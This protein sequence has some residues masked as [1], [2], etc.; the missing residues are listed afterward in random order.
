VKSNFATDSYSTAGGLAAVA[1]NDPDFFREVKNQIFQQSPTSDLDPNLPSSL[2]S[3]AFDQ[4]DKVRQLIE[5]GLDAFADSSEDFSD[6]LAVNERHTVE[7]LSKDIES[8]L[9]QE[10]DRLSSYTTPLEEYVSSAL[11]QLGL[12]ISPDLILSCAE[13][14]SGVF[15]LDPR[16]GSDID[17]IVSVMDNNPFTKISSVPPDT[18]I[19]IDNSADLDKDYRGVS[20]T[21]GYLTPADYY[22]NI[23]FPKNLKAA[24]EAGYVGYPQTP[25]ESLFNPAASTPLGSEG[26]TTTYLPQALAELSSESNLSQ[27]DRDLYNLSLMAIDLK[28]LTSYDPSTMS[29]GDL[30]D[31]SLLPKFDQLN[32]DS[33]SGS[34][35]SAR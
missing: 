2:F 34:I 12:S 4:G 26:A 13:K 27:A 35:P 30:L 18:I 14:I 9:L 29:S 11:N 5:Q 28:G 10:F 8:S 15:R 17:D 23:G 1:Y 31:I 33:S 32:M 24:A 6:W 7:K 20:I 16:I 19:A 3:G 21:N 22:N 25:L